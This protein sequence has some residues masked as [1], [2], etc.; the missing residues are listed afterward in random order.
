M[1]TRVTLV[2]LIVAALVAGY[3]V[4]FESGLTGEDGAGP[5][6]S[7]DKAG[8]PLF[9]ADRLT[10]AGV[11]RITLKL[12]DREPIVFDRE[13]DGEPWRQT[14]PFAFA[15]EGYLLD[16]LLNE[17]ADLRYFSRDAIGGEA[18]A[19]GLAPARFVVTLAGEH[20]GEAFEHTLKLGRT[21]AA[22]RAYLTL[23][24]GETVYLVD[25]V[26][27]QRLRGREPSDYRS[28]LLPEVAPH[29][30]GRLKLVY[31]GRATTLVRRDN[32]WL[33]DAPASGRASGDVV[34]EMLGLFGRTAV[35]GFVDDQ[36]QD[37]SRYGL[38]RPAIELQL[39]TDGDSESPSHA[40]RI[41]TAADLSN[42]KH[43]AQLAGV[44]AVFTLRSEDV[45]KLRRGVDDLRDPRLTPLRYGDLREVEVAGPGRTPLRFALASGKW[46]FGEPDPG[47]PIESTAVSEMIDGLL[48]A[49]AD[50]YAQA[51]E[52]DPPFDLT[53][54][55]SPAGDAGA[56]VLRIRRGDEHD[57]VVRGDE[58]IAYLVKRGELDGVFAGAWAYRSRRVLAVSP[59]AIERITVE[60]TG[61][62]AARHELVKR[63]GKWSLEGF[64]RRAVDALVAAFN[65]LR[66]GRWV[67]P[68]DPPPYDLTITVATSDQE[69]H[70]LQVSTAASIGALGE[71]QFTLDASVIEPLTAELRDRDLLA[72]AI[73]DIASVAV[74][75]ETY[76]RSDQGQY[77]RDGGGEL[78]EAKVGALFDTLAGLR[79]QRYL[80]AAWGEKIEATPVKLRITL[81][82]GESHELGVW[83]AEV[84][85]ADT[86][87][88]RMGERCFTLRPIGADAL[89]ALSRERPAD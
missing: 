35:S 88:G 87:I 77:T 50:R 14:G 74:G 85:G 32:A 54:R 41:G 70:K 60:R 2:V 63:D 16:G 86:P 3:F 34:G 28:R 21:G 62:Y 24:D 17:A 73:E 6:P 13:A 10:P 12:G 30:V 15:A 52:A 25:R 71:G 82:S 43:H 11:T 22:G 33:L 9:E 4:V 57:T 8:D 49:G 44:P 61:T 65:P 78:D 39:F 40:L 18:E 75:G 83:R 56:E 68:G 29:T 64:E 55:L 31:E 69:T 67:K 26:L 48:S 72:V 38:D 19:L 76:H 7:S 42:Q 45:D 27:H 23:G 37:F 58:R 66:C 84:E 81:R 47:L 53:V 79:A 46:E 89:M 1:N 36:P 51:T 5:T 59:A 80:P 20:E